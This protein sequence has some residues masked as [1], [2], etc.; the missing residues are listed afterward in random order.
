MARD[1]PALPRL[2][3]SLRLFFFMSEI[4]RS[5]SEMFFSSC[6]LLVRKSF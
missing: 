5:T 6:L 1:R 4:F 3:L 2:F